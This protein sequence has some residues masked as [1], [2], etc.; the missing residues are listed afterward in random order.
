MCR[1][2]LE[3]LQRLEA[4]VSLAEL[5]NHRRDATTLD[6]FFVDSPANVR[7]NHMSYVS[8]KTVHGIP[9]TEDDVFLKPP[10]WEDITSSIQVRDNSL[11]AKKGV[12]KH[13]TSDTFSNNSLH[14]TQT[15]ELCPT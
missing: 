3:R 7:L 4:E 12:V 11:V 13:S 1:Q 10:L 6:D 5:D 9:T 14:I 15:Y 2:E 8:P